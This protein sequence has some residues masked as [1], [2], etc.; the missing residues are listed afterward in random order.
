MYVCSARASDRKERITV[1]GRCW[2]G[3]ERN[4]FSNDGDGRED[5]R[6]GI[7]PVYNNV[8]RT[9]IYIY[10]Y[11]IRV[12]HRRKGRRRRGVRRCRY[13]LC[14]RRWWDADAAV[15]WMHIVK[16]AVEAYC[17]SSESRVFRLWRGESGFCCGAAFSA[18]GGIPG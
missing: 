4:F 14:H 6:I 10:L 18:E 8:S 12:Q 11:L 17:T 5:S 1:A 9:Y 16:A 13:V 7:R 2:A 15:E 3:G